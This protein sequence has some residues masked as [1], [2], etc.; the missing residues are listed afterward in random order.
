[1]N[2]PGRRTRRATL[3]DLPAIETLLGSAGLPT[4]GVAAILEGSRAGDFVVTEAPDGL[5]GCA[6][7]ETHRRRGLLRSVAVREDQRGRGVGEALVLDR[8]RRARALRLETL[9]LL[10]TSAAEWFRRFDFRVVERADVPEEIRAASEFAEACPASATVMVL[11]LASP[12][13]FVLVRTQF[14]G[15]LGMVC[16]V[17]KS[18]GFPDV[19]LVQPSLDPASPEARW[20]AHGGEDVL[21]GVRVFADLPAAVA[22]CF[23]SMGT[24][25][26]RRHWNRPMREPT[27]AAEEFREASAERRLAVVF[28]PE[29]DGLS[30]DELALC[31]AAISIPRPAAT[32]ATLSLPAAA[33]IVAWEIA[34][35]RGLELPPPIGRAEKVRRARRPLAT[36]ELSELANLVATSLEEIG[37]H[38]L[39]D[40]ARFRGSIRDFLARARPTHADRIFLR[41]LVAQI[42]KWKRRIAGEAR[43]GSA[44]MLHDRERT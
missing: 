19:R 5:L 6:A 7:I 22:D 2:A 29:D 14:A 17:A 37:L 15:N 43:R 13:A 32:G 34:K 41:H 23:R 31:D 21:D 40:A 38:P 33:T 35:A 30:N 26:R 36:S 39:P 4:E 27:D 12:V 1:L 10:T 28:G 9:H 11:S 44:A 3:A 18:F 24:T 25:A 20:F 8:I 16:R 42:G